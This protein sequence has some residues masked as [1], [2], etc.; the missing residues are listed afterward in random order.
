MEL[1]VTWFEYRPK[2]K[3]NLELPEDEQLSLEIKRL[4]PID[5]L[6]EDDEEKINQWRD[7]N[8]TKFLND[9]EYADNIKNMSGEVLR[10]V[11]RFVSHTRNFKNFV[12][13]G[14]EKKDSAE[15]FF[16]IP[17]PTDA[18]QE[19]SLIME[20]VSV[21]GE[22]AHLTGEELKNYVARSDGSISEQAKV[23]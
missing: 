18:D 21:L 23:A 11:K 10:L 2:W 1:G 20:I 6:Y 3:G 19:N 4:K 8:L 5:T 9:P 14:Q 16:N 22:T 13:D 7:Q 15:I 12:F 17:N